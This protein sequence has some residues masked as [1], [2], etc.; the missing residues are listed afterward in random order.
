MD[1]LIKKYVLNKAVPPGKTA[2]GPA[3]VGMG[4]ALTGLNLFN[5]V[6]FRP[7][8]GKNFP[9]PPIFNFFGSLGLK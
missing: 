2:V 4:G 8:A 7:I 9:V 1:F 3:N 6:L 5:N